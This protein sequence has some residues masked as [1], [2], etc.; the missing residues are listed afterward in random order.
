MKSRIY[1]AVGTALVCLLP[2]L[3]TAAPKNPVKKHMP[4]ANPYVVVIAQLQQAQTLLVD[5]NH[6]YD[7][8]RA[9]AVHQVTNALRALKGTPVAG[10]RSGGAIIENQAASDAQLRAASEQLLTIANGLGT[11]PNDPNAVSAMNSVL[12]AIQDINT[13]LK[14]R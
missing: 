5:A 14:I 8:Y 1:R 4:P 13:A 9:K 12:A 2:G 7:G 10:R 6:D 3:G 11:A